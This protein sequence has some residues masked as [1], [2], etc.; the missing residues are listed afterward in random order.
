VKGKEMPYTVL[1]EK[2][3]AGTTIVEKIVADWQI[4]V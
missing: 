1:L 3:T 2:L 4:S